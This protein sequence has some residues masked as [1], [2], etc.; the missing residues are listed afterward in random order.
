M[1]FQSTIQSSSIPPVTAPPHIGRHSESPTPPEA[2]Q[3]DGGGECSQ[4]RRPVDDEEASGGTNDVNRI[5]PEMDD[6]EA[7]DD[8]SH[9]LGTKQWKPSQFWAF[10][11][12]QLQ[13]TRKFI[14]DKTEDKQA[15][16]AEITTYVS[17]N[18]LFC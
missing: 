14:S 11:D 6:V 4:Q 13:I 17:V 12:E 5:E 2:F 18:Y 10:V 3:L 1:D 16:D 15:A 9:Q 7:D 8:A